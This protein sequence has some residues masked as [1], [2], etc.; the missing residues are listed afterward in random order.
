[1]TTSDLPS[2]QFQRSRA[3]R[4]NSNVVM[5]MVVVTAMP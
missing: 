2:D 4:K 3:T 5:S 1:V